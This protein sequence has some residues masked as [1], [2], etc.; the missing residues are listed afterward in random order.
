M[1]IWPAIANFEEQ[2]KGSIEVGKWADLVVLNQD[3]MRCTEQQIPSSEVA[4]TILNGEIVF[5]K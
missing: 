1:T 5:N 3:L 2:K 4:M